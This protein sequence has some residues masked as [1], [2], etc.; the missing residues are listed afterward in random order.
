MYTSGAAIFPDS[1]AQAR[2]LIEAEVANIARIELDEE[3]Q[4]LSRRALV[5]RQTCVSCQCRLSGPSSQLPATLSCGCSTV[6]AHCAASA[7]IDL[8]HFSSP[9]VCKTCSR[10]VDGCVAFCMT[11]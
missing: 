3:Q 9:Y 5:V 11:F 10:V 2:A 7:Y 8:L 4:L 6:C 1:L